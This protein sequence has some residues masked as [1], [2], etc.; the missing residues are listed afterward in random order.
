MKFGLYSSIASPPRGEHLERSIEEVIAEAQLAEAS[1]FD[2]CFFGEHHQDRDGFLPSPLIVA[3][4]VAA[5]TRQLRVGTSVILLPLHHPVRVA[6][7]AITLDLVS[8]G[9]LILGVGIGYQPADFRAFNVPMEHRVALFEEGVDIIRLCFSGEKFSYR[10]KHYVLDDLEIRPRPFQRPGPPLWIGA[11]VPAAA[12]RAGRIAD[13]FV[14]TPSTTLESTM[15]LVHPYQEAAREAGRAANVVMMRDA[16]VAPTRAEAEQVYGPHVM[17]AYRYY[18][19]NRLAEFRN[20]PADADFTLDLLAPDRLVVGDPETCVREFQ[21]WH[22]TT[23]ANYFLLRLRHAHS[24]GPAHD[25]IMEAI[26]LFGERV[27]PYCR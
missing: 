15:K 6:E 24:G 20:I 18:W 2:S 14:G 13:A 19:Q 4:A 12:R 3:T 17:T 23:G 26:K 10:G 21:R 27:L 22:E 1:G 7:D 16:W 25:K 11:S 9:R 8:R 5:R